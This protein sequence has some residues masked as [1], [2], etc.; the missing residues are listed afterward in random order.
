MKLAEHLP[1]SFWLAQLLE[2]GATS[3][4][5]GPGF[6]LGAGGPPPVQL[7]S[8]S[9]QDWQQYPFIQLAEHLPHFFW[10][11]QLLESGPLSEQVVMAWPTAAATG[12][13]AGATTLK[14]ELVPVYCTTLPF[15]SA[16]LL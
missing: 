5:V 12:V 6:G 15:F 8:Q 2:S 16:G 4:H 13:E 14:V 9:W 3:E 10:S 11:A 1:H 7:G